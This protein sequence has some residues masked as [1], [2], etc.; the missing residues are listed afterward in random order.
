[1][2]VFRKVVDIFSICY[3]YTLQ[4]IYHIIA[5]FIESYML[6]SVYSSPLPRSTTDS[7][8]YNLPLC[9]LF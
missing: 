5:F 2:L 7:F 3:K 1:M 8:T 6:Y 4:L 9:Q